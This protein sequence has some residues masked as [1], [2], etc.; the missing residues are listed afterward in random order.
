MNIAMISFTAALMVVGEAQ[1]QAAGE[2]LD[3]IRGCLLLP[4]P[5]R[6]ECL[7]A[8]STATPSPGSTSP[9][10]APSAPT[11]QGRAT[12]H[13]VVSQTVSPLDYSPVAVA[14]AVYG[15]PGGSQMVLT[16][17]CRSGRTE[18]ILTERGAAPRASK[19]TIFYAVNDN[20]PV[21]VSNTPATAG[22]GFVL[23]VD[24]HR[25]I[26][27]LPAQGEISFRVVSGQREDSEGRYGIGGLKG[28]LERMA[29]PCKWPTATTRP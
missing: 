2:V 16:V 29:V 27:S 21:V 19:G 25:L 13:W 7:D 24:V 11:Q 17:S 4:Q 10:T 26:A 6:L 1:A 8:I 9:S 5:D 22:P 20:Q 18:M 14:T 3:K 23:G 15:P 12:D 28:L